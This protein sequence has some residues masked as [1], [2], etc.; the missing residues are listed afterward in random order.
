MD[1][2]E[3][4]GQSGLGGGSRSFPP[5][6]PFADVAVG[7]HKLRLL[8]D[9]EQ[10]F[11]AMLDDIARART[12]VCFET[13]ILR[14]DRTGRTFGD[15]LMDR[16]SAGVEVNLLYDTWGS[17]VTDRFL[18]RLKRAGVRVLP[19]R[20]VTAGVR[21]R[22]LLRSLWR[23]DH[24]KSLIIDGLVGYTGGLN[25]SDEYAPPT[26]GG[27]NWRDTHLRIEGPAARELEYFF[28]RTWQRER[29]AP[30]AEAR[31]SAPPRTP[32]PRV[33]VICSEKRRGRGDIGRE[34]RDAIGGARSRIW[35]T[36]AYFL[37]TLRLLRA[38]SAAARRGV[39]VRVIVAGTTDVRAVRY[40]SRSI[41]GRL[42]RAGVRVYEYL[43]RVLHAKTA[44]VDGFWS[45]V[46][47]SNLDSQSLKMNLE[48]NAFVRGERFARALEE[49]F[50]EDLES[51]DEITLDSWER[52]GVVDRAL[53]WS[54]YLFKDY[55]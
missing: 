21:D 13:Y 30:L 55:L 32:D 26:V 8:R 16:A 48:V 15:A 10:A 18:A 46:G 6:A 3:E 36:N 29:G 20:P 34:Y 19:Y 44:V 54:A 35:L 28:L 11:P 52:R 5:A 4:A 51:C 2:D 14:D 50:R 25:I 47:S 27:S 22:R 39:D 24:K 33:Q 41:Y 42:L 31:Y 53:S 7:A 40:A 12:T 9:G 49:M 43:G 17:S 37:P 1:W 23:R 38:L 45:T